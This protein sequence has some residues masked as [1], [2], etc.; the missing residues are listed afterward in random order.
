MVPL[1]TLLLFGCH[2]DDPD[3]VRGP[4]TGNAST[5]HTI[6]QRSPTLFVGGHTS[7]HHATV[8]LRPDGTAVVV[9]GADFET[10]GA[11]VAMDGTVTPLPWGPNL[12]MN[13][14]QV[15]PTPW[16]Y[17][18]LATV[19]GPLGLIGT[20]V[21]RNGWDV[22]EPVVVAEGDTYVPDFQVRGDL[23]LMVWNNYLR[24]FCYEFTGVFAGPRAVSCPVRQNVDATIKIS[25]LRF[26]DDQIVYAW[27]EQKEDRS[28]YVY[29][30]AAAGDGLQTHL[31]AAMPAGGAPPARP[32][33][34]VDPTSGNHMVVWRGVEEGDPFVRS[35]LQ[36]FTSDG[37]LAGER[38]LLGPEPNRYTDWPTLAGPIDGALVLA[39]TQSS[40]L[41]LQLRDP[42]TGAPVSEPLAIGSENTRDPRRPYVAL[43]KTDDGEIIG[44]VSW[45]AALEVERSVT[46]ERQ[47][48]VVAFSVE[49]E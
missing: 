22:G 48:R 19:D 8:G 28:S 35:Y 15:Q 37:T 1:M 47:L 16:G 2:T 26:N 11:R 12:A 45:E 24:L 42:E 38:Y 46:P 36:S 25:T 9:F 20:P 23:G 43:T 6:V 33:I 34:A 40:Q 3:R 41:W 39:W 14:P 31:V 17:L 18:I 30:S 32:D 5:R 7:N 21:D 29:A 4:D 13:H 49:R 27:D 44:M 10:S